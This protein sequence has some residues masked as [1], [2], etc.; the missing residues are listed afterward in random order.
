MDTLIER[1]D[2]CKARIK[3]CLR[4]RMF[5]SGTILPDSAIKSVNIPLNKKICDYATDSPDFVKIVILQNKRVC[6]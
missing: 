1:L 2:K 4:F 5:P 6:T 3:F